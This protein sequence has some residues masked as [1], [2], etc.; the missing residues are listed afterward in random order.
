MKLQIIGLILPAKS[1]M[2]M[3]KNTVFFIIFLMLVTAVRAQDDT[4]QKGAPYRDGTC[5][6]SKYSFCPKNVVY[7]ETHSNFSYLTYNSINWERKLV[8]KPK[9]MMTVRLGA[10]YYNFVKL[11]LTGA[12]V[13][14]NFLVGGGKWLFDAGI[15]GTYLLVY[16]NYEEPGG[17]YKDLVHCVGVNAHAG[18]RYMIEKSFFFK[19]VID[20]M[21]IVL[22]Q[23]QVPLMTKAFQPMAGIGLG[24]TFN[25]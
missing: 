2:N 5:K 25:H 21:Y 3:Y 7:H 24:Y 15:G 13:G 1:G 6:P 20:P 14:L 17:S 23:D 8:C 10:I 12:P 16:K 11:G 4:K 9:F 18:I 19:A 22:G